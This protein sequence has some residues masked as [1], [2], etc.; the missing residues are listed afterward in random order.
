[1]ISDKQTIKNPKEI[2]TQR[3]LRLVACLH[4]AAGCDGGWQVGL[5]AWLPAGWPPV[6][7][8][9]QASA[10]HCCQV[11]A[12]CASCLPPTRRGGRPFFLKR[13]AGGAGTDDAGDMVLVQ[14]WNL[15]QRRKHPKLS[16]WQ[17]STRKNF[18]DEVRESA[19]HEKPKKRACASH[20]NAKGAY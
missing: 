3:I 19:S 1:M 2:T 9:G 17:L 20:D 11:G 10:E 15:S 14:T 16:G 18:R 8:L 4:L 7:Q 12:R 13:D 5:C 6:H